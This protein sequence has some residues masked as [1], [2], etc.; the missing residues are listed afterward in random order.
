MRRPFTI[1]LVLGLTASILPA[2]KPAAGRLSLS[3]TVQGSFSFAITSP[4]GTSS[5]ASQNE[6]VSITLGITE[7]TRFVLRATRAN[8]TASQFLL[9]IKF[10]STAQGWTVNGFSVSGGQEHTVDTS[11]PFDADIP[12]KIEN[13][14]NL[15]RPTS[16]TFSLIRTAG[17]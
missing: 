15:V 1:G 6:E 10:N 12:L 9:R 13:S 4:S 5:M 14:N 17:H 7:S 2:Q 16:I 3:A 8:L 11:L